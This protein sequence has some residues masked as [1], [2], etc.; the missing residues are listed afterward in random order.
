MGLMRTR[1][2]WLAWLL[3]AGM[4]LATGRAFAQTDYVPPD[5]VWPLPL[6]DDRPENGRLYTFGEYVMFRQTNPL[7]HQTIAVRGFFAR[8][9]SITGKVGFVGSGDVA[10]DA[11]QAGGPNS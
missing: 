5:P 2:I 8:D 4:T 1:T 3:V 9:T 7:R 11:R 6:C 10:L